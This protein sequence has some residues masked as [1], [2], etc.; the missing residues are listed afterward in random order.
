VKIV[1]VRDENGKEGTI[2]NYPI[3]VASITSTHTD[4]TH[5]IN[6]GNHSSAARV[7]L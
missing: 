4:Q 1:R 6:P 7:D 3:R 2:L 5:Q